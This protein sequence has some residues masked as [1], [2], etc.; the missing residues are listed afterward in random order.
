[1]EGDA[2]GAW[3]AR[4]SIQISHGELVALR[5]RDVDFAGHHIGV[6]ASDNEGH[7][8][9]QERQTRCVPWPLESALLG[10]RAA[11]STRKQ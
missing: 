9:P 10:D 6:R 11:A 8:H 5:W 7:H 2:A 3:R 1:M 4:V